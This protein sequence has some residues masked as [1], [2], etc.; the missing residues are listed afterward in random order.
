MTRYLVLIRYL[1]QSSQSSCACEDLYI[2]HL[3]KIIKCMLGIGS[4]SDPVRF[5]PDPDPWFFKNRIRIPDL[6]SWVP[7]TDLSN[8]FFIYQFRLSMQLSLDHK[9]DRHFF[10]NVPLVSEKILSD[11]TANSRIARLLNFLYRNTLRL[12]IHVL[13]NILF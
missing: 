13:C 3:G 6:G 4:V 9:N 12:N 10:T 11:P 8:V 7:N 1:V 2:E 5:R